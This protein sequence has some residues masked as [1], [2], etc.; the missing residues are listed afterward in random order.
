MGNQS[1]IMVVSSVYFHDMRPNDSFGLKVREGLEE[2]V[3]LKG[4]GL[5]GVQES[6]VASE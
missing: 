3:G 1:V 5:H 4:Q 2:R 6:R